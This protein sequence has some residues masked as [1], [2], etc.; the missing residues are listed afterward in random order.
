MVGEEV[1]G[2]VDDH[3]FLAGKRL[4]GVARDVEGLVFLVLGPHGLADVDVVHPV[5][6]VVLRFKAERAGLE[7]DVEILGDEDSRTFLGIRH[8]ARGG[9]DAV[10]RHG[11][12]GEE[13]LQQF[14]AGR[15]ADELPILAIEAGEWIEPD[16]KH[17]VVREFHAALHIVGGD[18]LFAE[19]TVDFAGIGAARGALALK[20]IEFLE[21]FH[22]KP[23]DVVLELERRTGIVNQYVGIEDVV[24]GGS[25]RRVGDLWW[26]HGWA[27]IATLRHPA[28][29]SRREIIATK[30][31]FAF[32]TKS[33]IPC[34]FRETTT[35]YRLYGDLRR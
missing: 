20:P 19:S 17:A 34:G 23:D 14:K 13:L 10:I 4:D 15:V 27:E 22:R 26:H 12:I 25:S 35:Q 1:R 11:H 7:H 33:T 5:G 6:A 24:F 18:E 21:D 9:D 8:G 30:R 29:A 32:G 28:Q 2:L 16:A 31:N 3:R